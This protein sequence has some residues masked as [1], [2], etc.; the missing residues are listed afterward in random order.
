MAVV[1]IIPFWQLI[2]WKWID[3]SADIQ[4]DHIHPTC[5]AGPIR[6]LSTEINWTRISFIV[7]QLNPWNQFNITDILSYSRQFTSQYLHYINCRWC[8][9]SIQTNS[10]PTVHIVSVIVVHMGLPKQFASTFTKCW[11]WVRICC[12]ISFWTF[13][14]FSPDRLAESAELGKRL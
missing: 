10:L 1:S 12:L 6:V 2:W 14:S 13:L 3:N 11:K 9:W 5:M 7:Q 4:C 8:R